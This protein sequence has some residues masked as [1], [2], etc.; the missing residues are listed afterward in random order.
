MLQALEPDVVKLDRK[1]ASNISSDKEKRLAAESVLKLA[2][3]MGS[4]ALAEGVEQPE[5]ARIL[6]EMGY[7]WQQGYLY[8]RPQWQPETVN[9]EVM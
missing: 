3:S 2:T 6:G 1:F 4:V 8:G 5:E 7:R 9:F